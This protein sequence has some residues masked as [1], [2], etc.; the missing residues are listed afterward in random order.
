M[1]RRGTATL[2]LALVLPALLVGPVA[3]SSAFDA[4]PAG[5]PSAVAPGSVGAEMPVTQIILKYRDA[6]AAS[7]AV[8]P[9]SATEMQRLSAASGVSLTYRRPM[10]GGAQVLA[11]PAPAP[12]VEA[13][14]IAAR[15]SA[16][17]EVAYA[18][19]DTLLQPA[20]DPN[21]TQYGSQWNLFAPGGNHYGINAPAA[22]DVT[23]GAAS[24]VVADIDTGIT[25]HA[26]FAGR[27]VPGYDFIW[28]SKVANDGDGRDADPSD[29]GDWVASGEC[30]SGSSAQNSSWHGTH[31]TGLIAATGNNGAGV[32]GVTWGSKLLPVRVLGKCGGYTSD[33]VDAMRWSAG[34]SVPGVHDNANPARVLNLSLGGSGSCGSAEQSA[35]NDVL[36]AG[37][38]IVIAAG[39][40][41]AN[42]G[43]FR[44]GN[45]S[46]VITVA[47]T[48]RI[49]SRAY[50]SNYGAVV[51]IS[52]PG[53]AMDYTNDSNGVLSTLNTGTKGPV[54]GTYVYYQG[55]SMAAPQVAGVVSLLY[56][57]KPSL[58]PA[59]V[60][61]VLQST[62]TPFPSGSTCNT[63]NCGPGILNAGAAVA[64]VKPPPPVLWIPLVAG[65]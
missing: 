63:A 54:A 56:S 45:C 2:L 22:W 62:V 64:A 50:Y 44:P 8:N 1:N 58:T 17:P 20:F 14:A 10:S 6:L 16:L 3:P 38:T 40:S 25:A 26:E 51:E 37:S 34:L 13:A 48:N 41:N 59:E 57:L 7:N 31:T 27:T 52:A 29:P 4:A 53:G 55:T 36:A 18:E 46:G 28:D 32:A 65:Q 19:P 33:I 39:N 15:L 21:D 24:V 61:A 35:I 43:S 23:T 42:A 49:G 12:P 60:L 30:Y 9:A 47:A 5:P 11:L